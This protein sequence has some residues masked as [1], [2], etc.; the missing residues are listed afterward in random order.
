MISI[1]DLNLAKRKKLLGIPYEFAGSSSG[2]NCLSFTFDSKYLA[3]VT[4]ESQT[5]LFYNWEKG[6]VESSLDLNVRS[7]NPSAKV[8]MISCNPSDVTIMAVAGVYSFKFLT[9]SETVWRPYGFSKAD[10]LIVTSIT[11]LNGDRLLAGLADCR[12]L[13][14]ENGE[15]KNIFRATEVN[16]MNLKIREEVVLHPANGQTDTTIDYDNG[17]NDNNVVCLTS[18]QRGFAYAIGS[19]ETTIVIVFE[20]DGQHKYA[21]RNVYGLPKSNLIKDKNLYRVNA[22]SSN[23]SADKLLITCGWSQLFCANLW[24]EAKNN[25]PENLDVIG[26]SLH[27]GPIGGLS[28]CTW[29]SQVV[30]YGE[31]DRT[32]RLWDFEDENLIMVKQYLERISCVVL[33]PTGLFCLIGFNDKLRLMSVLIDDF[34]PIKEFSIRSCKIAA[35]SFGGHLFAAV[36]G[37]II[38]VYSI[39]D[40]NIRFVLKGNLKKEKRKKKN[41]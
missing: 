5:M 32:V 40:F 12:I 14:L 8:K 18:F 35:F 19:S 36:D 21:K 39:M 17:D 13:Y 22:I 29:K 6:K 41:F 1:Y 25:E 2:F 24:H 30:T 9:V 10:N 31:I 16:L 28:A 3:G 23:V 15:L 34:L 4:N 20:K 11:W 33:H 37:N 27:Y 7:Q 26:Y 38:Q